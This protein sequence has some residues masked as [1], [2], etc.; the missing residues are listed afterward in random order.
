M[1]DLFGKVKRAISKLSQEQLKDL[2][3]RCKLCLILGGLKTC[4]C[5][6]LEEYVNITGLSKKQLLNWFE[7]NEKKVGK[8]T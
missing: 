8:S 6:S 1:I 3:G 5:L 4:S 7:K 2:C